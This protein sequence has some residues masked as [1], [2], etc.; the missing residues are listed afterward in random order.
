MTSSSPTNDRIK[1]DDLVQKFK[2]QGFLARRLFA[3]FTTPVNGLSPVMQ[4]LQAHLRYQVELEHKGVM[5][6]AGPLL[7]DDGE[8][9]EGEGMFIYRASS[10]A[11]AQSIAEADPMHSSGA[12]S[13]RIRP[14]IL[15][16][17][18]ITIS[19]DLSTG[20]FEVF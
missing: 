3:V 7:T 1:A 13:F 19:A 4:N 14:W 16:E 5:F 15:N 18:K 9:G 11:E 20:K 12:R 2:E 17:G 10:L 6:A 8:Y